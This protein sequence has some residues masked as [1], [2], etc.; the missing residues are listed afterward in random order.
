M[1]WRA[2]CT[3]TKGARFIAARTGVPSR[4][5]AMNLPRSRL[6]RAADTPPPSGRG[7][8]ELK[9]AEQKL[10]ALRAR[11]VSKAMPVSTDAN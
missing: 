3:V 7:R 1:K 5:G 9:N 8:A 4:I 2:Y 11:L 6:F 10:Q